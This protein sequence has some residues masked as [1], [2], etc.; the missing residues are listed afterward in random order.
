MGLLRNFR[1]LWYI[2]SRKIRVPKAYALEI[3][4][5]LDCDDDG[6]IDLSEVVQAVLNI[7]KE[8]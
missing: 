5:G 2:V 6:Y 1:D 3:V 7:R 8:F 4:G